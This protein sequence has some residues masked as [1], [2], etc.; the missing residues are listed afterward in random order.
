MIII[1]KNWKSQF[2]S[3]KKCGLYQF[4]KF[5]VLGRGTPDC[6]I[7]FIGEAPGK[8]E[9]LLGMPF[10]GP[11]GKL[12]D[13]LI[14]RAAELAKLE[15]KPRF[16][17]TNA[18]ACRPCDSKLG[19]NRAPTGEEVWACFP[20][21]EYEVNR[22]AKPKKTVFLGKTAAAACRKLIPDGIPLQHPA[23]VLRCGGIGC[24]E[25][26]RFARDLSVVFEEIKNGV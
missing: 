15:R 10:I 22:I 4:R 1:Q 16:Y 13:K 12:L 14:D 23:Y 18:C 26:I 7:L 24:P 8:S 20:R 3:C 5:V 19:E 2:L 25:G 6:D 9:N 21:L 17:I 11:S